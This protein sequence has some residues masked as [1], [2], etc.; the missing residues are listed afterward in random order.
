MF[1]IPSF[2]KITP[3]ML[4][5]SE[6]ADYWYLSSKFSA[7]EE[8]VG[9]TCFSAHYFV[10]LHLYPNFR[11][12]F[13]TGPQDL[14]LSP[15]RDNR[16]APS[17]PL[18]IDGG[19]LIF[20]LSLLLMYTINQNHFLNSGRVCPL[21]HQRKQDRMKEVKLFGKKFSQENLKS[22]PSW[23]A[24]WRKTRGFGHPPGT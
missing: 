10:F 12:C 14:L 9:L 4:I 20:H 2:H 3:F 23:W 13:S 18:W 16:R 24:F 22:D 21:H 17:C 1:I 7:E 15:C 19:S 6:G 8:V 11:S 5:L